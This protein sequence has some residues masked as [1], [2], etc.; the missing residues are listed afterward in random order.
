M[1]RCY[2]KLNFFFVRHYTHKELCTA[3]HKAHTPYEYWACVL[4]SVRP[5]PH[6]ILGLCIAIHKAH[7]P[8]L[9]GNFNNEN[10][11]MSAQP[12]DFSDFSPIQVKAGQPAQFF[13][14]LSWASLQLQFLQTHILT[15]YNQVK[16]QYQQ[17]LYVVGLYITFVDQPTTSPKF[18]FLKNTEKKK[19]KIQ[20]PFF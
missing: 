9:Y 8:F 6:L 15:L 3:I 4:Q 17:G 11:G 12:S 7:T 16:F 14:L 19:K 5:I 20:K 2:I 18:S 1:F 13:G 10:S